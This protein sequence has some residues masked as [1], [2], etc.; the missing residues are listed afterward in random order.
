MEND[1]NTTTSV[2]I[3]SG[4]RHE[5]NEQTGDLSEIR[6]GTLRVSPI[7]VVASSTSEMEDPQAYQEADR[8]FEHVRAHLLI[9]AKILEND[10]GP[11][12]SIMIDDSED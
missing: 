1:I 2:H 3:V 6:F 8:A 7:K 5:D 4:R 9:L 12:W 10:L 11:G